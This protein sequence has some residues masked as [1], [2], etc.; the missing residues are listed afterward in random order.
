MS[1]YTNSLGLLSLKKKIEY[2]DTYFD[3][4]KNCKDHF[5]LVTPFNKEAHAKI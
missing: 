4:A 2:F 1:N 3:S 5:F